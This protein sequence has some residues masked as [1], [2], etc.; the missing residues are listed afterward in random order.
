MGGFSGQSDMWCEHKTRPT[1]PSNA[2][3]PLANFYVSKGKAKR[4]WKDIS[5]DVSVM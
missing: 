2:R 5:S 1:F 4:P 3:V